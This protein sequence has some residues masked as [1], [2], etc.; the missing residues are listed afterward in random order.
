MW[1]QIVLYLLPWAPI[2]Y[3]QTEY[4]ILTIHHLESLSPNHETRL[5]SPGPCQMPISRVVR[6]FTGRAAALQPLVCF[7]APTIKERT[8]IVNSKV[9][10]TLLSLSEIWLRGPEFKLALLFALLKRKKNSM[11]LFKLIIFIASVVQ[12]NILI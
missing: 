9:I 10:L 7:R 3:L 4:K 11:I 1:E 2:I 8:G 12:M 5:W 6:S